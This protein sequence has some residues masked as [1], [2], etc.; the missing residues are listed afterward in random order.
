[1]PIWLIVISLFIIGLILLIIEMA[2]IPGFGLAGIL[3]FGSIILSCYTSF[4]SLSP[5]AGFLT[6]LGAIILVIVIFKILPKTPAW[7]KTQLSLSQKKNDGYQVADPEFKELLN[8][9][10]ICLTMLRPS[11]TAIINNK[12]YDVVSDGEFIE[13]DSPVIVYRVDGNKITVR[14]VA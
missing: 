7:K 3:G 2:V 10:G 13:K 5:L 12:H 6:S 9:T 11:G 4:K 14:K 8:K 1:M